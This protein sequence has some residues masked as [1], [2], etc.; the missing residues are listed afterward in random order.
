MALIQ[1]HASDG[2]ICNDCAA[3]S[4]RNRAAFRCRHAACV[5]RGAPP[6][7]THARSLSL[8][9]RSGV[10]LLGTRRVDAPPRND[11]QTVP[12]SR[13]KPG[14]GVVLR[15]AQFAGLSAPLSRAPHGAHRDSWIAVGQLANESLVDQPTGVDGCEPC[16]QPGI[17]RPLAPSPRTPRSFCLTAVIPRGLRV[18]DV[19]GDC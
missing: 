13:T 14:A 9:P 7:L 8:S 10:E 12:L 11:S 17:E 3:G 5:R 18:R 4:A 19:T 6:Q 1:P 15:D 16:R 2:A